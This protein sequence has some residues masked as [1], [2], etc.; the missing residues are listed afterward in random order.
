V[1]ELNPGAYGDIIDNLICLKGM[2]YFTASDAL[3]GSE[4]WR[5]DGSQAGTEVAD[6]LPGPAGSLPGQL[7]VA[8]GKLT[9]YTTA[10]ANRRQ[11]WQYDPAHPKW[12]FK[13]PIP[14]S[15]K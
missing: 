5:S 3:R 4:L 2:L 14:G 6:L 7:R 12:A 11:L 10:I 15:P 8:D 9:F 13:S 1:C